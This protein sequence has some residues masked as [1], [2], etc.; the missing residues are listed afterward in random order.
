M[1][2]KKENRILFR[3]YI[4]FWIFAVAIYLI[5][6]PQFH[7][8]A[9]NAETAVAQYDVGEL[10]SGITVTQDICVPSDRLETISV[11][12]AN[13]AR[14]NQSNMQLLV[15]DLDGNEIACA[16]VPLSE[17]KNW[18]YLDFRFPMPV[19]GKKGEVVRLSF[20]SEDSMPGNAVT[21]LHGSE[22]SKSI[23]VGF[24]SI[25]HEEQG[26]VLCIRAEGSNEISFYI[27]YWIVVILSFLVILILC[28]KFKKEAAQGKSNVLTMFLSLS[29]R[30]DFL[31][32]QLVSREFKVK[33]KRSVL[34]VTWSLLNPLL[35]M[36]IQYLVF[37]TLFKSDL[38]NYAAYLLIGI[39]FFNFF[40]E[41][42]ASGMTSITNNA[43]LIKK[44]YVP[45]YIFPISKVLAS[46]INLLLSFIPLLFVILASGLSIRPSAILVVFD[47]ICLLC[48]VLGLTMLLCTLMVFFQDMQFLWSIVCMM[49]MYCTPIFYPITIIPESILHYFKL[50]P[51]FQFIS[52]ARTCLISG[53]SPA[54]AAYFGYAIP[55]VFMLAFG[56]FVF[57]KKQNSFALYL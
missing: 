41:A 26:D 19:T 24:F 52:F 20:S 16:A 43:S 7:T 39:V 46:S 38:D 17:A 25:N 13:Y 11:K 31:L 5:A 57:R 10:V 3:L 44:V 48:F 14:E 2:K 47:L 50:N 21:L 42:V 9:V 8:E 12:V 36:T 33:Y 15:S 28:K 51:L 29:I 32:Q 40:S 34:G 27:L 37:S 45:K 18:E 55:A 1:L 6:S 23:A 35:T 4:I 30:Y 56:V 22:K 54:P 49:W 53:I